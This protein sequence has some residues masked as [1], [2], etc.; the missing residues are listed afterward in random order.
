MNNLQETNVPSSLPVV[1]GGNAL[2]T[3]EQLKLEAGL[4]WNFFNGLSSKQKIW[5]FLWI[6]AIMLSFSVNIFLISVN[7]P[8]HIPSGEER[9]VKPQKE[10]SSI[11]AF[12][13][14]IPLYL[15]GG[16]YLHFSYITSFK[17]ILTLLI[18]GVALYALMW[19]YVA[20][21]NPVIN[22][23]QE[24][25]QWAEE[26]YGIEMEGNGITPFNMVKENGEDLFG[27]IYENGEIITHHESDDGMI[28]VFYPSLKELPIVYNDSP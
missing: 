1:T 6:G 5:T 11:E 15:I 8:V 20:D 3:P 17:K 9:W 18:P 4:K 22:V 16:F 12:F 24:R 14:L 23:S 2:K 10:I 27:Y 28:L 13:A 26:R 21:N 7:T 19:V 25:N